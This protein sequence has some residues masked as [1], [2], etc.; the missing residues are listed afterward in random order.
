[1]F[2][3]GLNLIIYSKGHK[4]TMTEVVVNSNPARYVV[5]NFFVY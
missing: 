1:M 4:V 3:C 5:V 2:P